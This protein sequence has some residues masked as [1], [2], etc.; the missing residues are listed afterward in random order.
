MFH[1]LYYQENS[2]EVDFGEYEDSYL[3]VVVEERNNPIVFQKYMDNVY[4]S[5]PA[6]LKIVEDVADYSIADDVIDETQDTLTVLE[7]YVNDME[8]D[9][10]KKVLNNLFS[11]LYGEALSIE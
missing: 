6:D 3:K 2:Q 8:L 7:N 9:C 1:K 4:K 5:N 11:D 10:D